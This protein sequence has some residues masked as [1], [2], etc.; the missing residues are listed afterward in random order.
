[1]S[2]SSFSVRRCTPGKATP[3]R[4]HYDMW[5]LGDLGLFLAVSPAMFGGGYGWALVLFG[6]D[7]TGLEP[8]VL[9][10]AD[11]ET[12]DYGG[13]TRLHALAMLAAA[14]PN[15]ACRVS[16]RDN[17]DLFQRLRDWTR[18][19]RVKLELEGP[20]SPEVARVIAWV[21]DGGSGGLARRSENGGHELLRT[22]SL[23]HAIVTP[24][25]KNP[26][27]EKSIYL[28]VNSWSGRG[29]LDRPKGG[30]KPL[31][32]LIALLEDDGWRAY[33]GFTDW[34]HYR[35]PVAHGGMAELR[36]R[37]RF[38]AGLDLDG[39]RFQGQAAAGLQSL[40]HAGWG[41]VSSTISCLW[42]ADAGVNF[43]GR[44]HTRQFVLEEARRYIGHY[45]ARERRP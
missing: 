17:D 37:G 32:G 29:L 27:S 9:L 10:S 36:R 2:S 14:L 31:T 30:W 1:M 38:V 18:L 28:P 16:Q 40:G 12:D 19:A 13:G 26:P 41:S 21:D 6:T 25:D 42:E 3:D 24:L 43:V 44:Y 15:R 39:I 23:E 22:G 35:P 4:P 33:V 8:R 20:S 7:G 11:V 34:S 5:A 45:Y